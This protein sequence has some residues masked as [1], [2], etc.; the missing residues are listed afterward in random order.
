VDVLSDI[1]WIWKVASLMDFRQHLNDL[2]LKLQGEDCHILDLHTNVKAFG[3]KLALFYKQIS[4]KSFNY[5][6]CC[7]QYKNE[8][9]APFPASVVLEASSQLEQQFQHRQVF[10][11]A[12]CDI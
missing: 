1:L 11:R 9:A 12:S 4:K 10:D 2:N 8:C 3:Q 7:D 5:Y 6:A